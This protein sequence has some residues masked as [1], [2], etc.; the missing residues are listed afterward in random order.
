MTI[1][2]RG[3]TYDDLIRLLRE[4]MT[5]FGISCN[6]LDALSGLPTGYAGKILG[7]AKVRALGP[8]SF[9]NFMGALGLTF[10]IIEDAE[11]TARLK[12]RTENTKL[13]RKGVPYNGVRNRSLKDSL[14]RQ[15]IRYGR[16]GGRK[17]AERRMTIMTP[18]QRSEAARKSALTR[19]KKR[20]Q[21]GIMIEKQLER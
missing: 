9:D 18:E 11:A 15:A 4:R 17:S 10:A 20:R 8:L 14:R 3:R 6:E 12:A 13:V 16:M 1:L 5:A 19:W 7:A 21:I 2:A